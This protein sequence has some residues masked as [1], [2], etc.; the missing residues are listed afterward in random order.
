VLSEVLRNGAA[1]EFLS[2]Q[3]SL[4]A[5]KKH[6]VPRAKEALRPACAPAAASPQGRGTANTL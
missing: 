2:I 3:H 1:Q 6:S 4:D 5:Q